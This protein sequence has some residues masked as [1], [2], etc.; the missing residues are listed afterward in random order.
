MQQCLRK[1]QSE[2]ARDHA[3]LSANPEAPCVPLKQ[4][5][6]SG[7]LFAAVL[8]ADKNPPERVSALIVRSAAAA[9]FA[10]SRSPV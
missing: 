10:L 5:G 8:Q 6:V 1:N 2:L 4:V 7:P 9:A 3:G